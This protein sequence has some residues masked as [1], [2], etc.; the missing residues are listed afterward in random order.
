[1]N[2]DRTEWRARASLGGGFAAGYRGAGVLLHPTSLPTDYGIGDLGPAAHAWVD[3]LVRAGQTW[4]Q[5]LPLGQALLN[6][7]PYS[8]LGSFGGNPLLISPDALIADGLLSRADVAGVSFPDHHVDY[9]AVNEFKNH[10]W[11]SAYQAFHSR[12]YNELRASFEAFRGRADWLEDYALFVALKQQHHGAAYLEWSTE[13]IR[14]EPAALDRAREELAD[15][16]DRVRFQQFLF[17]RQARA[18]VEHARRVGLKLIDDLPI[19]VSADS[20]DV[21]SQPHLFLLD[22]HFRPAV[23]AGVPPDYFSPTGQLWGNPHYDWDAHRREQFRWWTRRIAARLE[24]VDLVRIDH[25]RGLAAAWQVAAGAANAVE[26]KWAPGPGEELFNQLQQNLGRLPLL[27]EDLGMITD[28]VLLL[29]DEFHLPGMRVL[30]FAF[31]GQPKNPFLPRNYVHN[32]VAYTGTHDNDTTRGWYSQL[33][34]EPKQAVR[35][36]LERPGLS[37]DEV[38]WEMIRLAHDSIAALVIVPLQDLLNLGS[39]ARMNVPGVAEGNWRW[40]FTAEMP[41]QEALAHLR[42]VTAQSQRLP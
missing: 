24:Y 22:E 19:F 29:R 27:A 7:S 18:L 32:T 26:G 41:V 13:L 33:A 31:D 14:R 30:Q 35:E 25:F 4:W 21:W 28:D 23:V 1:M 34:P 8:P 6:D 9:A 10:L 36:L 15:R 2:S 38:S 40:R 16:I 12:P 5:F 17:D 39:E 11:E 3:A 20:V 37:E 42:E